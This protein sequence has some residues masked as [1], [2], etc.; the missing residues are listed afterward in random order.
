MAASVAARH[1]LPFFLVGVLRDSQG[2]CSFE[3]RFWKTTTVPIYSNGS[4]LSQATNGEGDFKEH[5]LVVPVAQ[6]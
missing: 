3:G 1:A 6:G 4:Y 5:C 2:F